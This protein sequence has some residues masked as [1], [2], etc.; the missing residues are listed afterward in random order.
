MIKTI[1]HSIIS[2]LGWLM[3]GLIWISSCRPSQDKVEP[4]S[5]PLIDSTT[6]ILETTH[7]DYDTTL[8]K[9]IINS[10]T[11]QLDIRY[12]TVD[13]FTKEQIYECGRCFLRPIVAD[14]ILRL[15]HDI[16]ERYG[17][18]LVLYDCYRPLPAQY[19]LW[20][21]VPDARYVTPPHKGSMHN[22]GLAVDL[23]IIG[24]HGQPLDMGTSYDFFGPAAYTDYEHADPLIR[25]NR[26]ILHELMLLHGFTGIRTEWWHYSLKS[27]SFSLSDWVWECD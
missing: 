13:N 20:K 1:A 6:N 18:R 3:F 22:R 5:P 10:N 9:E 17:H 26:K 23:S 21:I 8:W 16:S 27:E 11:I 12:A 19:K 24:P 15:A 7:I 4:L 2:S 25:N 14:K